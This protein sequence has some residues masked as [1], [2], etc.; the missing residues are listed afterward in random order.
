MRDL[1]NEHFNSIVHTYGT[2]LKGFAWRYVKDPY[3]VEDIIQEVFLKCF[4][5]L[6]KLGDI[7]SM[8]AWLYTITKNQCKD[9]LRTKYHQ[10]VIPT[11]EFFISSSVTP[12]SEVMFQQTHTEIH[13]SIRGLPEKYQEV[14]YLSCVK[15]LKIKEIQQYLNLNIST[16]KTRLFRAKRLLKNYERIV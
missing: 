12:E 13:D 3:L 16:V 11:P 7:R 6:D 4:I 10:Y 5:H 9:Y 15:E 1:K 2:E 14:L 8:K